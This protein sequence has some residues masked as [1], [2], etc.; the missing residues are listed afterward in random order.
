[1][2]LFSFLA[3]AGAVVFGYLVYKKGFDG[4]VAAVGAFGATVLAYASGLFDNLF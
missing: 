1:M 3:V 2:G 4:A